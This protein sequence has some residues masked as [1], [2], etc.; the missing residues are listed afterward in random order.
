M[1][2]MAR[3]SAYAAAKAGVVGLTRS[4]AR[5]FGPDNIR[6]NAIAPGAVVTE[7]QRRLWLSEADVAEIVARQCLPRVLVAD[8]IARTALFLAADDSRMITKQCLIVD[9]GLR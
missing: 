1:M 2:G 6:V 4:L 5:E 9:A 7:R 8:E 3:L